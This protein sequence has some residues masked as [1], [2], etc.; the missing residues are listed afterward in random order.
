ML[1]D[2]LETFISVL[3]LY[4]LLI[5]KMPKFLKFPIIMDFGFDKILS[6]NYTDIY[7][8][9]YHKYLDKRNFEFIHGKA[10]EENLVLGSEETLYGNDINNEIFCVQF[11]KYFQRIYKKTGL[12]YKGWL[13]EDPSIG[14][15]HSVSIIGHSL[16]TTDGDALNHIITHPKVGKTTIFYHD[17]EAHARYIAN[18]VKII[19]K[20]EI[21]KR[22]G[23]QNIVLLKQPNMSSI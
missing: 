6:F 21:I 2:E 18:L 19:S 10:G 9:I 17:E 4:M 1:Y 22:I 20:D 11:K 7:S 8:D 14:S 16:D 3:E 15:K 5:N 12:K 13:D 23:N